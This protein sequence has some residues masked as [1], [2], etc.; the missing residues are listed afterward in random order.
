MPQT[1]SE[2]ALILLDSSFRPVSYNAEAIRALIYPQQVKN[3]HL[4]T[5]LET[6]LR[7]ILIPLR[8]SKQ[9]SP[10][11]IFHS[12]DRQYRVRL[13]SLNKSPNFSPSNPAHALILDRHDRTVV[14]IS[15][16]A[17]FFN[18]TPREQETLSFL[19]QGMTSKEIATQMGVSPHTIK[20]FL[21]LVMSKMH[22]STRSGIIGKLVSIHA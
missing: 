12:G 8:S 3:S 20:A 11:P 22:V 9:A 10:Q 5:A 15:T 17:A 16:A 6:K 7:A 21:R 19:I 13:F 14:D 4:A 1:A 2:P 18:L